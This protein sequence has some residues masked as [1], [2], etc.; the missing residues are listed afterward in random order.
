MKRVLL[1]V[2]V[3]ICLLS[4]FSCS[5]KSTR[6]IDFVDKVS[7]KSW[8]E[9]TFKVLSDKCSS[10]IS[11]YYNEDKDLKK[12]IIL[13]GTNDTINSLDKHLKHYLRYRDLFLSKLKE[14]INLL[15]KEITNIVISEDYYGIQT[16]KV[17]YTIFTDSMDKGIRFY[18]ELD[19]FNNIQELEEGFK[20]NGYYSIIKSKPECVVEYSLY[21][22]KV[23]FDTVISINPEGNIT[24]SI[25]HA[26]FGH[27]TDG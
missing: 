4:I 9:E 19:K 6:T 8:N 16:P 10:E 27:Y 11:R 12:F 17:S 20:E 21:L 26:F 13:R 23:S 24:Y 25:K 18:F 15:P 22:N 1:S 7:L 5:N 14:K 3:I 2:L